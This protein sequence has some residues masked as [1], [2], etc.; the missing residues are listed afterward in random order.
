MAGR[1]RDWVV[2]LVAVLALGS[3]AG[4]GGTTPHA[5]TCSQPTHPLDSGEP[6]QSAGSVGPVPQAADVP[7][8]LSLTMDGLDLDLF[9]TIRIG[10]PPP[11]PP[12]GPGLWLYATVARPTAPVPHDHTGVWEAELAAG[13]VADRCAGDNTN[14]SWVVNGVTIH[15][16]GTPSGDDEGGMGSARAGQ[17]FAAQASGESD[18]AMIDGIDGVLTSYGLTPTQV[19]VV[20]PLGP[21]VHWWPPS[22][23]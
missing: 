19:R 3:C 11:D 9:S 10:S 7:T 6:G 21:A 23:T 13:A 14:L 20:H 16:E 18:Q 2:P 5:T 8:A 12:R 17:I 15:T 1:A 22:M 4:S